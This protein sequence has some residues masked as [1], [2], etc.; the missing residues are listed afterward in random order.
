MTPLRQTRYFIAVATQ[1][2]GISR[3]ILPLALRPVEERMDVSPSAMVCT[4]RPT[5]L[6]SHSLEDYSVVRH[7]MARHGDLP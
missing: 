7:L 1:A 3:P 6:S 2:G 5:S 4:T